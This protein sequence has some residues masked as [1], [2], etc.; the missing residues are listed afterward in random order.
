MD[1]L[2]EQCGAR[3]PFVPS[4]DLGNV[5]GKAFGVLYD[6]DDNKKIREVEML[7]ASKTLGKLK[8]LFDR[9]M[10]FGHPIFLPV[11]T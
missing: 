7:R 2:F 11:T 10:G 3:K 9:L 6:T 5:T 4:R 1:E 8:V